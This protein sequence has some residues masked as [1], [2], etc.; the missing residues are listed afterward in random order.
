VTASDWELKIGVTLYFSI[1][2]PSSS[3]N[4]KRINS[5]AGWLTDVENKNPAYLINLIYFPA[6]KS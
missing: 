4:K 3:A 6:K 5:F 1:H 2:F